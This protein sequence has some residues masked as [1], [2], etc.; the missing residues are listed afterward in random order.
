[1]HVKGLP[2]IRSTLCLTLKKKVESIKRYILQ[3]LK[4]QHVTYRESKT[5]RLEK[6]NHAAVGL[7]VRLFSYRTYHAVLKKKLWMKL[8]NISNVLLEGINK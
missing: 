4:E 3:L 2:Q 1:M 7:I 8:F 6:F 5:D